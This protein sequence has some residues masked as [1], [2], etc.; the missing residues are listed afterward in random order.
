MSKHR[1]NRRTIGSIS[2][3]EPLESRRLLTTAAVS[4]WNDVA[5]GDALLTTN[6]VPSTGPVDGQ[7][8]TIRALVDYYDTV[9]TGSS[10]QPFTIELA[11]NTT[12]TLSNTYD[13]SSIWGGRNNE[14][15]AYGALDVQPAEPAGPLIIEGGPGTILTC[16]V[17]GSSS[18]GYFPVDRLIHVIS[19]SVELQD[20]TLKGGLALDNG[21]GYEATACLGGGVLV[22]PGGSL[23]LTSCSI[24]SNAAGDPSVYSGNAG[25]GAAGGGIYAS[26]GSVLNINGAT[27]FANNRVIAPAG[28]S[29]GSS[30]GAGGNAFGGGLGMAAPLI[31][32]QQVGVLPLPNTQLSLTAT[33]GEHATFQDNRLNSV[34]LPTGATIQMGGSGGAGTQTGG[35]GGNASGAGLYLGSGQLNLNGGSST[36]PTADE[37]TGNQ[38]RAGTG[39]YTDTLPNLGAGGTAYGAGAYLIPGQVA[40]IDSTS[41]GG[42]LQFTDNTQTS[43]TGYTTPSP[44]PI[45][46]T[47]TTGLYLPPIA[48]N[49]D[50]GYTSAEGAWNLRTAVA[51]ANPLV[52]SGMD[53]TL[54]LPGLAAGSD[55]SLVSDTG[56]NSGS[57]VVSDSGDGK[58]KILGGGLSSTII[59][60]SSL[61]A[62]VFSFSNA[63]V[64]LFD[65]TITGASTTSDG[66]AIDAIDSEVKISNASLRQ[67]TSDAEGGGIYQS[68]GTLAILHSKIASNTASESGGGIYIL[69]SDTVNFT[70]VSVSKNLVDGDGTGSGGGLYLSGST[71]TTTG[72]TDQSNQIRA[73]NNQ[74][75]E[76]AGIFAT[77]S[78][79]NFNG[80]TAET[81]SISGNSLTG[82]GSGTALGAG[83]ALTHGQVNDNSPLDLENN[84]IT[85]TENGVG[86]AIA[87][88]ADSPYVSSYSITVTGNGASAGG[89]DYAFVVPDTSDSNQAGEAGPGGINYYTSGDGSLRSAI[90]YCENFM[91]AT[92]SDIKSM[93]IMLSPGKYIVSSSY[94]QLVSDLGAG[95]SLTII[96]EDGPA[97]IDAGGHARDFDVEGSGSLVLQNLSITGG[98]NGAEGGGI[99]QQSGAL[100]LTGDTL[101]GNTAGSGGTAKDPSQ[102]KYGGSWSSAFAFFGPGGTTGPDRSEWGFGLWG[103]ALS[104]RRDPGSVVE[105]D[106]HGQYGDRSEGAPGQNGANR[107]T[108]TTMRDGSFIFVYATGQAGGTGGAG[109][110]AL[111][112][113]LYQAGG[114]LNSP[115]G[116]SNILGNS[117]DPGSGG[118]GGEGGEGATADI[119]NSELKGPNGVPGKTGAAGASSP[120]YDRGGGETVFTSN[121]TSSAMVVSGGLYSVAGTL[122]GPGTGT[123]GAD[124]AS[125]A[126]GR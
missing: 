58:L 31:G 63:D 85:E 54:N 65:L 40:V 124:A 52:S 3:L 125:S 105:Y 117:A 88:L 5:T 81:T 122:N 6:F 86:G 64:K 78:T 84:L 77:G 97:T 57:L 83:I 91:S 99:Y 2:P 90:G 114:T 7:Q 126:R 75:I 110:S 32:P 37:F 79:L 109:G 15:N 82:D 39:Y 107:T 49:T 50:V 22:N 87:F 36:S 123:G 20:M 53:I 73:V 62:S 101:T 16:T 66:G 76:G 35:V 67:N 120:N 25:Q 100:T 26:A 98:Y 4:S 113:G 102:T 74:T 59:D 17:Y 68:G 38:A 28:A 33:S 48:T 11:A 116:A 44:E 29:E 71:L 121:A 8:Y 21:S 94:G 55:Y 111:G 46:A 14:A 12:Y 72:F 103:R 27:N 93:A 30:G 92:G 56:E 51:V 45:A 69:N 112:G 108:Y 115:V 18:T 19:G 47:T 80:G 13:S 1:R 23:S 9:G 118:A 104:R 95:D 43:Y 106:H 89:N 34:A 96:A 60:A 119:Y 70:G 42:I 10:S 24:K 61:G 41:S